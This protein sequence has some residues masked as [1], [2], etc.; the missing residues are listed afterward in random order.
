MYTSWG[1]IRKKKVCIGAK[2]ARTHLPLGGES[3]WNHSAK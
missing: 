3:P 1:Q 2:V